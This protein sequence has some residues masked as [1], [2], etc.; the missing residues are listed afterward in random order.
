MRKKDAPSSQSSHQ[1]N[2]KQLL[3]SM[4]LV[5]ERHCAEAYFVLKLAPIRHAFDL[6][7][8]DDPMT[9]DTVLKLNIHMH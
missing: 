3:A 7:E 8:A 4:S 1:N 2:P 9:D 5:L 6:L